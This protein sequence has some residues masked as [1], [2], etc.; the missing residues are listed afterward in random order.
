MRDER[1]GKVAMVFLGGIGLLILLVFASIFATTFRRI[2]AAQSWVETECEIVASRTARFEHPEGDSWDA[3]VTWRYQVGDTHY[4]QVD[5]DPVVFG[6]ALD[7]DEAEAMA[8]RFSPGKTV[9]CYYDPDD[10]RTCKL[11]RSAPPWSAI[12]FAIVIAFLLLATV[13]GGVVTV[14]VHRRRTR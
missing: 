4:E 2:Y 7:E 11:D 1:L 13:V 12:V 9:P 14:V 8:A 5:A 10:P 3:L 6:V